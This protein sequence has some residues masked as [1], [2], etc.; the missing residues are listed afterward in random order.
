MNIAQARTLSFPVV[1]ENGTVVECEA[2][3][4]FDS[5]R[6]GKSYLVY[7]DNSIDESGALTLF[8]SSYRK[9]AFD[10]GA[11][12]LRQTDLLP[13]QSSAEWELV[14]TALTAAAEN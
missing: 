5:N 3:L 7:T 9:R 13:I 11:G 14:E 4:A 2:L 12:S 6:F 1:Q 8:A 10:K